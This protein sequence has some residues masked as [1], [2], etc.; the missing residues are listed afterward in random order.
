[1]RNELCTA[2]RYEEKGLHEY[3]C[4][5]CAI[6]MGYAVHYKPKAKKPAE[7]VVNENTPNCD[8]C[9]RLTMQTADEFAD[10]FCPMRG[11]VY[12]DPK[13]QVCDDYQP[14]GESK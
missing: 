3:P 10:N 6:A 4:R 14:K 5:T 12:G 13:S 2:C 11:V 1:M 9:G 7:T 8:N